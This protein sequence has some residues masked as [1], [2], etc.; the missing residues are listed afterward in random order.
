MKITCNPTMW[1][2][3]LMRGH[4]SSQPSAAGICIFSENE[5][6]SHRLFVTVFI[7]KK[8]INY[9]HNTGNTKNREGRKPNGNHRLP[10]PQR[11]SGDL[12]PTSSD[13]CFKESQPLAWARPCR[14][15]CLCH[16]PAGRGRFLIRMRPCS[17]PLDCF[18][19]LA[20]T[21]SPGLVEVLTTLYQ[22]GS[23]CP[24]PGPSDRGAPLPPTR[25]RA[26]QGDLW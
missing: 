23:L 22:V 15:T 8:M 9:G 19:L 13:S 6:T 18:Q 21:S 25:L 2:S 12:F 1:G 10:S 14:Q 17:W 26:R 11:L 16:S 24:P 3:L 5:I 4:I 20:E 7:R